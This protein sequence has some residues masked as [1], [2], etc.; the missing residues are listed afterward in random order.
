MAFSRTAPYKSSYPELGKAA[1]L[2]NPNLGPTPQEDGGLS[3]I[4]H[5]FGKPHSPVSQ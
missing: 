3:L 1:N 2:A 4:K 5:Q